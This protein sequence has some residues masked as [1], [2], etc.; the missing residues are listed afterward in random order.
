MIDFTYFL[1]IGS[2]IFG[3]LSAGAWLAACFVKVSAEKAEQIYKK[4]HPKGSVGQLITE[5]GNDLELTMSRQARWN[6]AAA[7]FAAC[8]IGSQALSQVV[9][10]P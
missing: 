3:L 5:D 4:Q 10:L 6:A 7:F 8:S 1:T 2:I 9:L